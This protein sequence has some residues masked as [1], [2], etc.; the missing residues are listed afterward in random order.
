MGLSCV[1]KQIFLF[2]GVGASAA[3]THFLGLLVA[4]QWLAFSPAWGNVFGFCCAFIVSFLGHLHLTFRQRQT[5]S[6]I[7]GHLWRWLLTSLAA[8]GL[9]QC[10]FVLGIA[11]LTEQYY[12]IV[13]FFVTLL[14][15]VLTFLSGKLWAFR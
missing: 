2:I 11:W 10:L 12:L 14:V 9:N 4:V 7:S 15:T 6:K 1:M 8:F 5:H 13:W 3:L